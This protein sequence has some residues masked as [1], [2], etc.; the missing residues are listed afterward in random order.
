MHFGILSTLAQTALSVDVLRPIFTEEHLEGLR[1]QTEAL[2]LHGFNAYRDHALP[3]DELRPL[4]CEGVGPDPD[5]SHI[6]RNDV[7]GN[8]SVTLI[9][10][11]DMF[12]I[13]GDQENFEYWVD[14][15]DK[16]ISFDQP[17]IIQVFEATIRVIGGLLSA[18]L[19]AS[20]PKLGHAIPGYNG[21]LLLKAHDLGKRLL[22]AF[23]TPTG[24][25]HPRVHLQNGIVPIGED[26]IDETCS[27]AA[28]SLMLEFGLLSRLTNDT[29]FDSLAKRAFYKVW[30]MRN[31]Q[32]DLVG[33]LLSSETGRWLDDFTSIGA[34]VDSFYEYILKS[35]ILFEDSDLGNIWDKV[36]PSIQQYL[37]NGFYYHTVRYSN[38][39]VMATSVDS[40]CAFWSGV[41]VL[42][43][44]ISAAVNTHL[45][46]FKLWNNWGGLPERWS[47]AFDKSDHRSINLEWYLLRPEFA[48]STYYLYQATKDPF[49][50]QVGQVIL[51]DLVNINKVDCGV[52]ATQDVR[53]GELSDRMDSF[54][55][56]ETVKY[57]YLLFSPDHPLNQ[58]DKVVF[59]TEAH[60]FWSSFY[61]EANLNLE[62]K[63]DE[64]DPG[65]LEW[66]LSILRKSTP[67]KEGHCTAWPRTNTH[68]F[69]A[70]WGHFYFIDSE[71]EFIRPSWLYRKQDIEHMYNFQ[72]VYVAGDATCEDPDL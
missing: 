19:Y 18:H 67:P 23:D 60:P 51:E 10:S 9:D 47:F 8:F 56:S 41:Q 50:L 68:S 69:V 64:Q 36:Y 39:R 22:P 24:I 49:Y 30:S 38:P 3:K 27:A 62:S 32:I 48:E 17:Q 7:M 14:Y 34:G 29:R 55:L 20:V 21:S 58:D 12:P 33:N 2:F 59:S 54:F 53:N 11:L 13:L 28:G 44:D 16:H 45:G 37:R 15:I 1:N 66:A 5:I 40:L 26:L 63:T 57:L 31:P 4:S 6:Q 70:S 52:A 71:T 42:A 65:I 72:D 46:Y 43:G 61:S 35:S 25:P